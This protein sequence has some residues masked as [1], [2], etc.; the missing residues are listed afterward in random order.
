MNCPIC[1]KE[2]EKGGIIAEKAIT[3]M[4]HPDAEFQKK[5]LKSYI[6]RRGKLLGTHHPLR[7][8]IKIPDAWYCS[9]C[10]K[11]TGTFDVTGEFDA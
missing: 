8:V 7:A 5:G 4:W 3:V 1:G 6:F 2:M 10:N 9:K 11:V